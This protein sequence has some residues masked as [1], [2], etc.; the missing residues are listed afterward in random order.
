MGYSNKIFKPQKWFQVSASFLCEI[1]SLSSDVSQIFIEKPFPKLRNEPGW[2]Q[3]ATTNLTLTGW[4]SF[5][6][7]QNRGPSVVKSFV[8]TLSLRCAEILLCKPRPR[9][10]YHW[11]L[12]RP[13]MRTRS[14]NQGCLQSR[15]WA[16]SFDWEE[17]LCHRFGQSKGQ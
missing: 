1:R 15:T 2:F 9:I 7:S 3:G 14:P 16:E 10:G 8:P 12:S 4:S 6:R 17:I 5:L 13:V 11:P